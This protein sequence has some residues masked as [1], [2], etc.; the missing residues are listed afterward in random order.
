MCPSG[1]FGEANRKEQERWR[2]QLPFDRLGCTNTKNLI[3]FE[4]WRIYSSVLQIAK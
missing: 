3:K 4:N 1:G 2:M